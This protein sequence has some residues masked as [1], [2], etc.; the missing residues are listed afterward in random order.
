MDDENKTK[1]Q[2]IV[3]IKILRQQVAQFEKAE[4]ALKVSEE[5]YRTIIENI[6]DGYYE[7]DLAGNLTFFNDALCRITGF[8]RDQFMGLN[9]REYTDEENAKKIY[10]TYNAVYQTGKP[11]RGIEYEISHRDGGKR[12]L[13]N[14]VSL[15][16]DSSGKPIGFRGIT[17]DISDRKRTEELLQRLSMSDGLTEIPNR[18]YFDQFLDREWRR[19][20]RMTAPLSIIM[21]DIDFFKY[22]NDLYGHQAGDVCLKK[23]A[24]VLTGCLK[25]PA[26]LVARYGG[27]EFVIVMPGTDLKGASSIAETLRTKV[28]AL[29]IL[30]AKS[31]VSNWVTIS[32]GVAAT[33]PSSDS[34]PFNLVQASDQALYEAKHQG[35][36][37]I[38]L[39]QG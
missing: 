28:E 14:S 38:A 32:L 25:R 6:E 19:A 36:N 3:E 15:I 18:R 21:A 10:K 1:E 4:S 7:V 11:T 17:R 33:I 2:L 16:H 8:S 22:Y 12:Y 35:R 37:R 26:D 29:G 31:T 13:E 9:N 30:H 24:Q 27:E 23:V 39:A 5:R 20:Q 34:T